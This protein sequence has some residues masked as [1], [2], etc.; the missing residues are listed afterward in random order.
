VLEHGTAR[1]SDLSSLDGFVFSSL[2]ERPTSTVSQTKAPKR[3][4]SRILRYNVIT[5]MIS[6]RIGDA[7]APL[8]VICILGIFLFPALQG[9]YSVVHGPASALLAIRAAAKVQI[10]IAQAA[11][12]SLGTLNSPLVAFCG[13]LVAETVLYTI[14]LLERNAILRC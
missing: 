2:R 4:R 12:R 11:L 3:V 8:A 1:R 6:G 10:A 13:I 9:P 7:F 5:S 14:I